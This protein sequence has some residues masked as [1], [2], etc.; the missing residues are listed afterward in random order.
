MDGRRVF[1]TFIEELPLP[2]VYPQKVLHSFNQQCL[3]SAFCVAALFQTMRVQC[4]ILDRFLFS[5][6]ILGSNSRQSFCLSLLDRCRHVLQASSSS[7]YDVVE[8]EESI[9]VDCGGKALATQLNTHRKISVLERHRQDALWGLPASSAESSCFR[10]GGM[11]S[12]SK[13]KPNKKQQRVTCTCTY[14]HTKRQET[15]KMERVNTRVTLTKFSKNTF[16]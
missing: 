10:L 14:K 3:P 5:Q 6:L 13:P 9:E 11:H 12:L 7:A 15:L 8:R 4:F 1:L 16:K 2:F